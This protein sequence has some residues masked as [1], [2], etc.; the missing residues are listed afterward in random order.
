MTGAFLVTVVSTVYSPT[1][2]STVPRTSAISAALTRTI[3]LILLSGILPTVKANCWIDNNGY[4]QC[5]DLSTGARIGIGIGLWIIFL[6]LIVS[7]IMYRRRRAARANL[8]FTQ[9]QQA[10]GNLFGGQV[11]Y[12][13]QYPPQAYGGPGGIHPYAY[14]PNAGFAPPGGSP[15]QYYPP[16]TGAPPMEHQKMPYNV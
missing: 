12:Q 9:N 3:V 16:P 7:L 5:D 14:D 6:S 10:G 13:P 2:H 8:A 11:P 15:P 1:L 4:E